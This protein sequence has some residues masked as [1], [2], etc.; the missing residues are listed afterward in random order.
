MDP[1]H[2]LFAAMRVENAM[3][4]R[5]EASAPWG[6][7]SRQGEGT[8]FA[9]VLSGEGFVSLGEELTPVP[10]RMSAGDC[11]VIPHG[12]AY[13]IFDDPLSKA[14]NCVDLVSQNAGG[15]V[16]IGGE[17]HRTTII[18][19]WFEFDKEGARPLFEALPEFMHIPMRPEQAEVLSLALQML[20]LE[21]G[22]P[23]LGSSLTISRLADIIFVQAVRAFIATL[24]SERNVGWLAA[25]SDQKIGKALNILHGNLAFNWTI[26]S[27][28]RIAG[29]S[30]SSFAVRFR[31]K[32]GA[33]P[34]EYITKWR[35]FRA[36]DLL[37]SGTMAL[38]EI[39]ETVGY[40]S[41]AAFNKVFKRLVG[42]TPGSYRR[43]YRH[44]PPAVRSGRP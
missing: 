22:P 2:D 20:A 15:V 9:L 42:M 33:S 35:M 44:N 29:M 23:G 43:Q 36:T 28:A 41:E 5:L 37:K 1:L 19:G 10:V 14:I 24:D 25:L 31:S 27:L 30:R 16:R 32:V 38:N 3:Y 18:S 40:K 11:F 6:L 13:A 7:S 39:A 26:D 12:H 8:R 4:A 17:G 21:T 34:L